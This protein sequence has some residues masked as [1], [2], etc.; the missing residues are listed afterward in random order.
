MSTVKNKITPKISC[1]HMA[2]P[3][4]LL[5]IDFSVFKKTAKERGK[6]LTLKAQWKAKNLGRWKRKEYIVN[7]HFT[8]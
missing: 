2:A 4:L 3:R 8:F 7:E 1:G 6:L 5:T